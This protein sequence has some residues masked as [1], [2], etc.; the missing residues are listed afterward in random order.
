MFLD[1]VFCLYELYWMFG[2]YWLCEFLG[3]IWNIVIL[4]DKNWKK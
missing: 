2:L 3:F 1:N 4:C